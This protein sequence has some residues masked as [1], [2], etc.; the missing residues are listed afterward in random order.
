M[1]AAPLPNGSAGQSPLAST[2]ALGTASSRL[3]LT[4][5]DFCCGTCDV[6]PQ[7][8]IDYCGEQPSIAL[9]RSGFDARSLIG[10]EAPSTD[11]AA[12]TGAD[13]ADMAGFDCRPP[14]NVRGTMDDIAGSWPSTLHYSLRRSRFDRP[15]SI[16]RRNASRLDDRLNLRS[17][18]SRSSRFEPPV[19]TGTVM[20]HGP[21]SARRLGRRQPRRHTAQN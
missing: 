4:R 14:D 6:L 8:I 1:D 16:R 20:R 13:M 10:A 19:P 15:K 7:S 5:P 9:V 2:A 21:P 3:S 12:E 11:P 18:A 17:G